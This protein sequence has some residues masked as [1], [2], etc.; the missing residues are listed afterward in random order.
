MCQDLSEVLWEANRAYQREGYCSE[1]RAYVLE[2]NLVE[3]SDALVVL[4]VLLLV[5][6]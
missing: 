5:V 3:E 6:F 4:L 1:V 2:A